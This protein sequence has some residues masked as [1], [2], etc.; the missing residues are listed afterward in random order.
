M[1]FFSSST[2]CYVFFH[3]QQRKKKLCTKKI[4]NFSF[5]FFPPPLPVFSCTHVHLRARAAACKEIFHLNLRSTRVGERRTEICDFSPQISECDAGCHIGN[6]LGVTRFFL[7]LIAVS[8]FRAPPS[9]SSSSLNYEV[10]ASVEL[11][12]QRISWWIIAITAKWIC[13]FCF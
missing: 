9:S 1:F 2:C 11:T 4:S 13:V 12:S 7:S 6:E 3:Q 8:A 10:R 5:A